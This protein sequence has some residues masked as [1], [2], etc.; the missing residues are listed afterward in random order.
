MLLVVA[1]IANNTIIKTIMKKKTLDKI[2]MLLEDEDKHMEGI[3]IINKKRNTMRVIN[4]KIITTKRNKKE[5]EE[6]AINKEGRG[7]RED[8]NDSLDIEGNNINTP[9][10]RKSIMR[11]NNKNGKLIQRKN[12]SNKNKLFKNLFKTLPH[13]QKNKKSRNSRKRVKIKGLLRNQSTSLNVI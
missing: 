13:N 8:I 2:I 1:L 7:D 9:Q 3:K 5:E 12:K 4:K 11:M 6:E 10:K